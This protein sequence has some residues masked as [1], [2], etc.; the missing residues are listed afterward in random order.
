MEADSQ[1]GK[2]NDYMDKWRKIELRHVTAT[3]GFVYLLSHELMPG[4]YKIGFTPRNP[5]KR[6]EELSREHKLPSDFKVEKYWRTED[7]YIVEQRIHKDLQDN[8]KPGEFFAGDLSYFKS[9]VESHV[10]KPE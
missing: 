3:S 5:D 10:I 1:E 7:P 6:A 8:Q 2:F 9:V 4:I